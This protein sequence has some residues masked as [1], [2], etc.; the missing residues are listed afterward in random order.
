M[1]EDMRPEAMT[2]CYS[3]R[4]MR[5]QYGHRDNIFKIQQRLAA[6]EQRPGERLS[7]FAAKIMDIGFGKRV[8]AESYVEAFLHGINKQTAATQI[9]GRDPRTL[10]DALQYA[11]DTCGG[12]GEGL[13]VTDCYREDRGMAGMEQGLGSSD[14]AP[15]QFD[16]HGNPENQMSKVIKTDPLS[17][18]AQQAPILT[19]GSRQQ[20][21]QHSKST[22][23]KP[24]ARVLEMKA[25]LAEEMKAAV[26]AAKEYDN[27]QPARTA[28]GGIRI[29]EEVKGATVDKTTWYTTGQQERSRFSNRRP[30]PAVA[31][32]VREV[33]GGVSV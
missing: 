8:P 32:A 25:E 18:A 21:D 17:I 29:P 5:K 1:T 4:K 19:A 3:V 16:V 30:A 12:Y 15:P 14:E 11:K 22:V 2:L 7:A 10:K 33:T 20:E 28:Q 31:T 13:K 26:L 6:R 9:R 23:A 27:Q 24:K